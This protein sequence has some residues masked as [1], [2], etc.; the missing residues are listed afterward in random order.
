MLFEWD[1]AVANG[2]TAMNPKFRNSAIKCNML[3]KPVN[4]A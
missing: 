1:S 2:V 3:L 4:E